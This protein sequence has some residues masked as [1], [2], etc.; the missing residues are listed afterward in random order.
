MRLC[1][2]RGQ[3]A[4]DSGGSVL[5]VAA[6]P[7][8]RD[9]VCIVKPSGE[10]YAAFNPK[11][12]GFGIMC[13]VKTHK[14]VLSNTSLPIPVRN[15]IVVYQPNETMRID[16]RLENE[17]V[18]L[19]QGQ[20][21]ELFGVVKSNVSY[22]LKNIFGTGELDYEATVQK[23]RTVRIEAGRRVL[24]DLEYFNLDVIISLGYRINSRL[25]IQFRQ[26]ATRVLKEFMLRGYAF[27]QR[28]NQ[29][30]D[31][32]DRRMSKTEADV[33]EL[34][35]KVDFFVQTSLP[36]T[37]G[38]FYDGQVFDAKV[39]AAKHILS[40]RK[41]ILLIDSW[42]DVVTLEL[43][44]KKA[45]GVTVEIVASPRGNKISPND[46]AMFNKQ[47]GGLSIRTNKNFHDRFLII[48]DKVLYLIGASLKDLGWKCFAFT[49]LDAAEIPNLKARV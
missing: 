42:V 4:S 28:L 5:C 38:I 26:W 12:C 46:I 47:Y 21:C 19:T 3:I 9:F 13:G 48:D 45:K 7:P 32:V 30:E 18:W 39:F 14:A 2:D 33:V 27:N 25:G 49:K 1:P 31:K 8:R 36:P 29:L 17:T 10:E 20:L 16:V 11:P 23:I 15:E 22:H 37:R 35:E 34:K 44:A 41:S 24:R 6:N 43:L 40:A